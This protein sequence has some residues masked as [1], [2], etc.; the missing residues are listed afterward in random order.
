MLSQREWPLSIEADEEALSLTERNIE[1]LLGGEFRPLETKR[2]P[3]RHILEK[4]GH[5]RVE[6]LKKKSMTRNQVSNQKKS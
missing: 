4:R 1:G 2:S 6:D 3:S 5:D